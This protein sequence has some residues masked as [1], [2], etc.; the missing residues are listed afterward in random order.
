MV[1]YTVTLPPKL[2]EWLA[3]EADRTGVTPA[4]VLH[5]LVEQAAA[6]Q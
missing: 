5:R 1:A 3:G 6:D 4:E 2:D